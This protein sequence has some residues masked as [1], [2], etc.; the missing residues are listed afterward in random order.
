MH[1]MK[2]KIHS[3]Y[4]IEDIVE[5]RL[6]K[7]CVILRSRMY[8]MTNRTHKETSHAT[9][10]QLWWRCPP[11]APPPPLYCKRKR[12][13]NQPRYSTGGCNAVVVCVRQDHPQQYTEH[14]NNRVYTAVVPM[15]TIEPRA[16]VVADDFTCSIHNGKGHFQ[17]PLL[18]GETPR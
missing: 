15:H 18:R 11:H 1:K 7:L 14:R 16:L 2:K 10:T 5:T 13:K 12:Q 9:R 8:T 6:C 3:S 4:E 17:P